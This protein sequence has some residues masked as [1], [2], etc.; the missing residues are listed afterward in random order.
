MKKIFLFVFISS[1]FIIANQSLNNKPLHF[2]QHID[3]CIDGYLYRGFVDENN[4][5]DPSSI[6]QVM[7]KES[8]HNKVLPQTCQTTQTTKSDKK[9]P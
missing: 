1:S 3:E 9:K 6:H 5:I 2:P 4:I 8:L 7:T